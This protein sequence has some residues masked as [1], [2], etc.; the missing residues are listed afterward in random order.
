MT[1][2]EMEVA[3]SK[4]KEV[5]GEIADQLRECDAQLCDM[6]IALSMTKAKAGAQ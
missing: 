4:L 3:V 6:L 2:A 5:R 1:I